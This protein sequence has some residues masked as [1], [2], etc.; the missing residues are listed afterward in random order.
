[1]T[2]LCLV[3][4]GVVAAHLA[5]AD[6]TLAW[7]HSVERTRWEERYR[8]DGTHLRLV[9]ASV[10][11]MGAG[12]EPPPGAHYADGRW[13]WRP[14]QSLHDELR[15]TL[16]EYTA[17]YDLCIAA[18]CKPLAALVAPAHPDVVVVRPCDS[19]ASTR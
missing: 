7:R 9:E 4:G 11:G 10:E 13:T 12:M 1:M 6:F 16:S 3:A 19:A 15:L 5:T 2:G 14:A 18:H 8:V 17:D